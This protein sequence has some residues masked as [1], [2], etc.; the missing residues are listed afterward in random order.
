MRK[1]TPSNNMN[2]TRSEE[3]E[4]II[5]CSL[6]HFEYD[7]AVMLAEVYHET[8]NTSDSLYL[9][10]YCLT[11]AERLEAAYN[12]LKLKF[13]SSPEIRYLFAHCCYHLEK[14]QEAEMA[15]RIH[16]QPKLDDCF[17]NT[18]VESFAHSLLSRVFVET[19]RPDEAADEGKLAL[20]QNVF[21]WTSLKTLCNLGVGN[22]ENIY[23][24]L[25]TCVN[26]A[27]S[28][29]KPKTSKS[30]GV[31]MRSVEK[32]TRNAEKRTPSGSKEIEQKVTCFAPKKGIAAK[33][34]T[35]L[36]IVKRRLEEGM[37]TRRSVRSYGVSQDSEN[38]TVAKDLRTSTRSRV[39]GLSASGTPRSLQDK[40]LRSVNRINEIE[41]S[42]TPPPIPSIHKLMESNDDLPETPPKLQDESA[43]Q[44][45]KSSLS[46]RRSGSQPSVIPL[47]SHDQNT[48]QF[49]Q[50]PE[51][52]GVSVVFSRSSSSVSLTSSCSPQPTRH[53]SREKFRWETCTRIMKRLHSFVSRPPSVQR[54]QR[55]ITDWSALFTTVVEHISWLAMLQ[56]A[57]ATYRSNSVI[58]RYNL[59]PEKC[60]KFA[61]ARELLAR[62]YLEKLDYTKATEILEELHQEFPHRV[63]G[64][65]ILSTAL[66]HAQDVR[67]L[68]VL[69]MQITE[70]CR[71]CPEGWCVAG[72]CFSVQK[73]HD[74]AIECFERAVTINTRFPYA[75]TLLGH[76]L[77][78]SDHQS[79]AAAAFR[80]A[81]LLCPTDYRAW[82]GLGLLHFKKE[83][84]N[85]ARVHLSRAVAINPFNSVLLCQLSVVEQA[86]HNNDTAMELLQ[87]ALK[88]SPD[89]AACRFYR[90]RLL[91]EMHDYAQCLEEL[92]DLKLIAH[93]E[94]QVFFLLG[95]VHKKLGD[96][97]LALLNFSLAAEMDPRGEQSR[98]NFTDA[99][100]DDEPSSPP[101]E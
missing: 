89:N 12:L 78:D 59:M 40:Q 52:L 96:T 95:R 9:Y 55:C 88:I 17:T 99:P 24:S 74:T 6:Q 98:N 83:Q 81:L 38:Q 37:E 84:V 10:A 28:A 63:A 92:N 65:E 2:P 49:K 72:N 68:S 75:Y 57:V 36:G 11:R 4:N 62:A 93:D 76:E 60:K 32:V 56:C 13:L 15:L 45:Q 97:H 29:D 79:K 20:K 19:G 67:R 3:I 73:Q 47:S 66:W 34:N 22:P 86:L 7:D 70:E 90:A 87:N 39:A 91:Y 26:E 14:Y 51:S 27:R 85:L 46:R 25:L 71:F 33:R 1:V 80:R 54:L 30:T 69:A 101:S 48:V 44:A 53:R 100:Y 94:A 16:D 35:E 77:L 64:M 41:L 31:P 50:E 43:H 21:S 8:V 61:L 5:H 58:G 18:S 82:F 42:K 23:T